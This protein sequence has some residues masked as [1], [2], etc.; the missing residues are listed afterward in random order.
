MLDGAALFL[1]SFAAA[2]K[3]KP[4]ESL[5]DWSDKFRRLSPK[6][7]SE[8]GPW[9]T[10]RVPFARAIMDSLDPSDPVQEVVYQA[11]TQVVK[12]S[13]GLNW[14]GKTI[15][16]D[17]APFMWVLPTIDVGQRLAKTRLA[18]MIQESIVLRQRVSAD[19]T[20][21]SSNTTLMKEFPSGFLIIAGANSPASLAS[22][23][24]AKLFL[25]EIDKYPRDVGRDK[26][27][28]GEG[29]AVDLAEARTS[30][31][32][33]RKIFKCSSPTIKSLSRI[34]QEYEASSQGRYYVPCPHCLEK[35]VLVRENL[36]YPEGKPELAKFKCVGCEELIDEHHKTWMLEQ[37]EWRHAY[38]ERYNIKRGF[39][40]SAWYTPIGLGH[41]WARLAA[42]YEEV[43]RN[44]TRLKV[45]VNTVDGICYEDPNERL[46]WEELKARA[47]NFAIGTVLPGY[48]FLTCGVDVQKDR[49]EFMVRAWGKGMRSQVV[50]QGIFTGDPMRDEIWQKLDEYL[51]RPFRNEFG[52]DLKIRATAIDSGYLPDRVYAFTRTRKGRN[53]F[54]IKGMPGAGRAIL[55]RPNKVDVKRSSGAVEKRGAEVWLVGVDAA[56][57][58]EFARLAWDR[59]VELAAD[60]MVRFSNE[61][62]DEFFR[63]LCAEIW[64]PH[65]RKWVSVYERNEMLDC[66]NYA[67]AAA[68][69]PNLRLQRLRDPQWDR[70]IEML[71]PSGQRDLFGQPITA[72]IEA[73]PKPA[74]PDATQVGGEDWLG[75]HN[76]DNWI[77]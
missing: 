25:D 26:D 46:D 16:R 72:P 73:T 33:K 8:H 52:V 62:S 68:H 31:F 19:R 35:Q 20:R 75:K 21:D 40:I 45:F 29:D 34:D 2:V 47:E 22:M 13:I 54:A 50:D 27:G 44:P 57:H 76:V 38:P 74:A 18:P 63:Q 12:T 36:F 61:L 4:V 65:K 17:P 30:T 1:E 77:T 24:I 51:Q 41:T 5:S 70:F 59:K 48:V 55:G 64:D 56:K 53:V 23:P 15:H 39:H 60:R 67:L 14:I 49:L 32:W 10:A 37:G 9:R 43:K 42:R 11:S 69:H 3:P 71:Q 58:E 6:E 66:N 28:G 7:A